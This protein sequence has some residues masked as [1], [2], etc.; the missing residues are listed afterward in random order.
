MKLRT[1]L[2]SMQI[3]GISAFICIVLMGLLRSLLLG[4]TALAAFIAFLVIMFL[5]MKCP[6][7]GLN[8]YT[9]KD[10]FWITNR[11]PYC[12]GDLELRKYK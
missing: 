3:L 10:H 4:L 1:A 11:C 7:C 12:D 8:L 5:H 9:V 6:Y 2:I